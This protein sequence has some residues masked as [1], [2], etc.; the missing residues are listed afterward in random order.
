MKKK[1]IAKVA[2]TLSAMGLIGALL[3]ISSPSLKA[4]APEAAADGARRARTPRGA[5]VAPLKDWSKYYSG[6]VWEKV[7]KALESV[8]ADTPDGTTQIQGDDIKLMVQ[9]NKTKEAKAAVIESHR[10]YIDV[11][12]SIKGGETF[13]WFPTQSLTVKKEY[14][15]AKDIMFYEQTEPLAQFN[16]R[17]GVFAVFTST[18]A[19][20]TGIYPEGATASTEARKAVVKVRASL[21]RPAR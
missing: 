7:F 17:P 3:G 18:D 8:N 21:L 2:A 4:Q 9:T 15:E 6:P 20:S 12:M 11:Q 16:A 10:E 14:D 13:R 1:S 5:F 19:H